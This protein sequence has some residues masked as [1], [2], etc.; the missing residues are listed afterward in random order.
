[1]ECGILQGSVLGIFMFLL[2]LNDLRTTCSES[3]VT[4]FADD[5]KFINAGKT[6][7]SLVDEGHYNY[8]HVV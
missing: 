4:M 2:Y 3:K 1:M 6:V 5:L 8:D 7:E